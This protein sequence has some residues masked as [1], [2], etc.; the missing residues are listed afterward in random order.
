MTMI[1]TRDPVAAGA[2]YVAPKAETVCV[3]AARDNAALRASSEQRKA[4]Y[5]KYRAL[6]PEE[7]AR[8]VA[9]TE[10][11]PDWRTKNV[12]LGIY[13]VLRIVGLSREYVYSLIR[14]GEFPAQFKV[15]ER[16]VRWWSQDIVSYLNGKRS[17]WR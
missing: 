13:E 1:S 16:R 17:G 12:P 11:P 6:T 3:Q 9:R 7:R 4:A 5:R 8:R 15:S 2:I 14:K 10:L